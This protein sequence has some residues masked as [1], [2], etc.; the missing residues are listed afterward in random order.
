MDRSPPA[1]D[2]LRKTSTYVVEGEFYKPDTIFE[3]I[4]GSRVIE[5]GI[6]EIM[7]PKLG[8]YLAIK[9][10]SIITDAV[11]E[12][13]RETGTAAV[14]RLLL[15]PHGIFSFRKAN[16]TD[17]PNYE[18][19][20][21]L[22]FDEAKKFLA[23]PSSIGLGFPG[24]NTLHNLK[25]LTGENKLTD[26]DYQGDGLEESAEE[27]EYIGP[28]VVS[29]FEDRDDYR[30]LVDAVSEKRRETMEVIRQERQ[31]KQ[32]MEALKKPGPLPSRKEEFKVDQK[33]IA[34]GV[35]TFFGVLF[36]SA[37]VNVIHNPHKVEHVTK[38]MEKVAN[39]PAEAT[40][41]A[42]KKVPQGRAPYVLPSSTP[43]PTPPANPRRKVARGR[44][45]PVEESQVQMP[46]ASQTV[47]PPV[48]ASLGN[49]E[50]SRWSQE[51]RKNPKNVFARRELS[52]AYLLKGDT[53]GSIKEFY[54]VMKLKNL[55]SQEII[56]YANNLTVYGS[57][58]VA[59]QF[60]RQILRSDPSRKAIR[61]RLTEI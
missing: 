35:V 20:L 29:E 28:E 34:A 57:P 46:R 52:Q 58:E 9:N 19:G 51:I 32:T 10:N 39:A 1:G 33:L 54:Q 43:N 48:V 37:V 12:E 2:F 3:V 55:S 53:N 17:K 50:I 22:S 56:N 7:G 18:Q 42:P 38:A 60:L 8:G 11:V 44:S 4:A 15:M 45:S 16:P 25:A 47:G 23:G 27:M 36:A 13:T 14:C 26:P 31:D 21:S 40:A 24:R 6:I 61:D 5:E 49:D 59:R 41:P 30:Q